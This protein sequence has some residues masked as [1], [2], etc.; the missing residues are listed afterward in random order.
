MQLQPVPPHTKMQMQ[1]MLWRTI[2]TRQN[3]ASV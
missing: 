2:N 1:E 3:Y